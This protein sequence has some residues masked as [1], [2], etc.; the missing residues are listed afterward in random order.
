MLWTYVEEYSYWP[1]SAEILVLILL[2]KIYNWLNLL[3]TS[4]EFDC[5]NLYIH[6]KNHYEVIQFGNVQ[7]IDFSF[8]QLNKRSVYKLNYLDEIGQRKV[9]Y[10]LG[11]RMLQEFYVLKQNKEH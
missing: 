11:G 6:R 2:P 10:T 1:A 8:L 4:V 7:P 5:D 3:P 9:L